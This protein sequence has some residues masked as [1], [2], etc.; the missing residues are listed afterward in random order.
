MPR[1]YSIFIRP[2][3]QILL[4]PLSLNPVRMKVYLRLGYLLLA[5]FSV[6]TPAAAQYEAALPACN[7]LHFNHLK[8]NVDI[9]NMVA[10]HIYE[11][12]DGFIWLSTETGLCRFDGNRFEYFNNESASTGLRLTDTSVFCQD[13]QGHIWVG[14]QQTLS[15]LDYHKDRFTNVAYTVAGGKPLGTITALTL[16][17]NT[18]WVGTN[19]GLFQ[20]RTD[21]AIELHPLQAEGIDQSAPLEVTCLLAVTPD[22][23]WI[24]TRR[25]GLFKARIRSGADQLLTPIQVAGWMPDEMIDLVRYD[26]RHLLAVTPHELALIDTELNHRTLLRSPHI[27][28]ASVTSTGEIWCSTF[29]EG[30]F[31]FEHAAAHMK[32]Y[33]YDDLDNSTFNHINGTFVD[34]KDNFWILPEKLGVRWLSHRSRSITN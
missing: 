13:R 31:Y 23:L 1:K 29:G 18:L 17:D 28:S 30:L 33:Q 8:D 24:G 22:E 32:H 4:G 26:D 10:N 12:R 7:Y 11:D 20:G 9:A 15:R 2:N 34:S 19:A 16:S 14:C 27:T 25:R 5:L 6:F 21:G 3:L